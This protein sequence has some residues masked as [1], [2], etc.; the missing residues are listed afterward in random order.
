MR[1]K[2]GPVL[3]FFEGSPAF[4]CSDRSFWWISGLLEHLKRLTCWLKLCVLHRRMK[5]LACCLTETLAMAGQ[6]EVS[7]KQDV[8][9]KAK[10]CFET[11][12]DYDDYDCNS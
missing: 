3:C 9:I 8:T 10:C 1:L 4:L 6:S 5:M 7:F 2:L 12:Y 11:H